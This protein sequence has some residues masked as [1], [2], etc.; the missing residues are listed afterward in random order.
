M[1]V[2]QTSNDRGLENLE[3]LNGIQQRSLDLGGVLFF[4]VLLLLAIGWHLIA[5]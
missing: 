5:N 4:A 2:K 3:K 1:K